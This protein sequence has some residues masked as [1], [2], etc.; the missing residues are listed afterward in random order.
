MFKPHKELGQNFL[1]DKNVA[2]EMVNALEI[3]NGDEIVEIGPG[4]GVVTN[5]LLEKAGSLDVS[6]HAVELDPRLYQELQ[7][8]Y[9]G[10]EKIEIIK[11]NILDWLPGFSTEKNLKI[12][13]SIPY[14]ITSPI[15][16]KII[17]MKS[18]P[19][20]VVLLMQ[21]EVAEKIKSTAPDSSYMSSFVQTFFDVK[22]LGKVPSK[23]FNPEPKVDGGIL[24]MTRRDIDFNADFIRK[25]EGFLHRAYSNPRKMLNK[26]FKK[27]ELE[28]GTI[29]EH[30]RAQNLG[31]DEW[32]S[33]YKILYEV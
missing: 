13:G 30:L 32:L 6:I 7:N 15:I 33:F 5:L 16:H 23:K 24:K 27:E 25:Y 9:A 8:L 12:I 3:E 18:V 1:T 29:D 26:V 10:R 20:T 19:K 31:A 17:K 2:I 21:K 28:R 14:Y 22:Y 4:H 11:D